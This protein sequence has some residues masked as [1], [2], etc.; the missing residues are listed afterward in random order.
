MQHS[1][2]PKLKR[3]TP[4]I[5][6]N[7][8]INQSINR[9]NQ[10]I[11]LNEIL[12][13]FLPGQSLRYSYKTTHW[14]ASCLH[15]MTFL[16]YPQDAKTVPCR[17]KAQLTCQT[18]SSWLK[19]DRSQASKQSINQSIN[20]WNEVAAPRY[21]PWQLN[22]NSLSHSTEQT[23]LQTPYYDVFNRKKTYPLRSAVCVKVGEPLSS[24]CTWKILTRWSEEHVA[25]D[26]PKWSNLTSCCT[27]YISPSENWSNAA[28]FGSKIVQSYHEILMAGIDSAQNLNRRILSVQ[29]G[30]QTRRRWLVNSDLFT[31]WK[32]NHTIFG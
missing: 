15:T 12:H 23:C 14:L 31:C 17:G 7:Q 28:F 27:E 30:L 29:H 24:F 5:K 16:S 8:S 2:L 6:I 13:V 9:I 11:N 10:S 1:S 32:V 18:A 22:L 19:N 26:V 4:V 25:K 3:I 20:Q 21:N